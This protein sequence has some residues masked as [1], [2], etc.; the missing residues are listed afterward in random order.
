MGWQNSDPEMQKIARFMIRAK[1]HPGVPRGFLM[2]IHGLNG[3]THRSVK[4][5]ET[6]ADGS[7]RTDR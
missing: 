3:A 6:N 7:S 1:Y 2:V 4:A 5:Q